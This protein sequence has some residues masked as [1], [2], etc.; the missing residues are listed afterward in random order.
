MPKQEFTRV[1]RNDGFG[2]ELIL[3][4]EQGNE[5]MPQEI[6]DSYW[7]D[8]MHGG[9]KTKAEAPYSYSEFYI[10]RDADLTHSTGDYTDRMQGWDIEKW[11]AAW[12]AMPKGK[13][14]P[15][16]T[17]KDCEKFLS[18][19]HGRPIKA[20]GLI[21]GCNRGSGYPYWVFL[22]EAQPEY[23]PENRA[24]EE[25]R[26]KRNARRRFLYSQKKAAKGGPCLN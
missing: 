19:Y 2:P 13:G 10:W 7:V 14:L 22:Y 21:E 16:F 12:A 15:Q 9:R 23:W 8:P 5:Y 17:K 24:K 3:V 20:M 18:I 1:F 11:K 25:K 4:D 6:D 26:R